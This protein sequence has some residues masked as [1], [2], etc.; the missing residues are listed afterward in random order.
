MFN[1][2]GSLAYM[3]QDDYDHW[4]EVSQEAPDWPM[5]KEKYA[6][7]ARDLTL[8]QAEGMLKLLHED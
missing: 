6:T 5:L 2:R 4:V 7:V 1:N 8:E 3:R